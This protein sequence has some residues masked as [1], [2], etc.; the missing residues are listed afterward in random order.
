MK[1]G[2]SISHFE[3]EESSL[4]EEFALK[5][6][7]SGE[8]QVY[9][10]KLFDDLLPHH[11]LRVDKSDYDS[12]KQLSKTHSTVSDDG[13]K[14][15]RFFDDEEVKAMPAKVTETSGGET[16]CGMTPGQRREELNQ[17]YKLFNVDNEVIDEGKFFGSLSG[18]DDEHGGLRQRARHAHG[19]RAATHAPDREGDLV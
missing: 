2:Q 14:P 7:Q 4:F 19:H 9:Y 18:S 8:A 1:L 10:Q 5:G 16:P 12:I 13:P 11:V 17:L 15:G 3:E 6:V